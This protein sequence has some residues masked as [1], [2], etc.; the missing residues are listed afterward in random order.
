MR[1]VRFVEPSS[2]RGGR[3]FQPVSELDLHDLIES[4]AATLPGPDGNVVVVPEM[5]SPLGLP[6]FVALVGGSSWLHARM[7]AGVAPVLS[8]S[9]C[10]VLAAA[11]PL[12]A[13]SGESIT[14]R[15]GW[16]SGELSTGLARLQRNG[17]VA[18][19]SSG[20]VLSHPSLRP[21]GSLV[22]IEAKV[23]DWRRAVRQ[24][25]TYRTWANNYVVVLGDVGQLAEDRAVAGV[26][27]DG[28]GLFTRSGWMVR[29]RS[30][31]PA[32]ARRLQGFEYLYAALV[33]DPAL[34]RLE[35]FDSSQEG[36]N[37]PT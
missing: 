2:S 24:G 22:A 27:A 35:E 18:V 13:L 12:R 25:R 23:K 3:R 4:V 30:R 29:P 11:S 31:V 15:L 34:G 28:G 32:A 19:S 6:D 9:D 26:L 17:A 1:Q 21:V 16:S 5:P 8:Q 20:S 33:S 7:T 37:P 36:R 10:T 14:R